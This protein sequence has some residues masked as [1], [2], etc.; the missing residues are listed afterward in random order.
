MDFRG[1]WTEAAGWKASPTGPHAERVHRYASVRCLSANG[2]GFANVRTLAV[3]AAI[4]SNRS[5]RVIRGL[6]SS[7]FDLV[8]LARLDGY[9]L[10]ERFAV[11]NHKTRAAKLD[12]VLG[13]EF[14]QRARHRLAGRANELSN[15]F[16]R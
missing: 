6:S 10:F 3:A 8:Q 16:V 9:E 13:L 7:P 5:I 12:Q 15:L 11:A 1:K 2:D 4:R 14:A